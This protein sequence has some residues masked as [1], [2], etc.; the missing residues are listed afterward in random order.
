MEASGVN[1][2]GTDTTRSPGSEPPRADVMVRFSEPELQAF[3]AEV[4]QLLAAVRSRARAE[5]Q[6]TRQITARAMEALGVI[7]TA[8]RSHP[9]AGQTRRLVRFIAGCYN[10]SDYPFD[11]T[12]LRALDSPLVRACLD[13]LDY[14]RL[15]IEEIHHHL[16]GGEQTLHQWLRDYEIRVASLPRR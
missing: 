5:E 8:I 12:D 14:D 15:S 4:R 2:T 11:L 16:P 6:T 13:Y 7:A 1:Q 3:K 9:G 10:G